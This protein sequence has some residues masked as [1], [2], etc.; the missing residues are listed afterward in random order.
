MPEPGFNEGG[1]SK[2]SIDI[3]M[4]AGGPSK[5][6]GMEPQKVSFSGSMK[7]EDNQNKTIL[8]DPIPGTVYGS[9]RKK[10]EEQIEAGNIPQSVIDQANV[11]NLLDDEEMQRR[12]QEANFYAVQREEQYAR[13]D[14]ILGRLTNAESVADV[15]ATLDV[16][17]DFM[18][19]SK[20]EASDPYSFRYYTKTALDGAR[21]FSKTHQQLADEGIVRGPLRR[22]GTYGNA[23]GVDGY[24]VEGAQVL[25]NGYAIRVEKDIEEKPNG[26][27]KV[28]ERYYYGTEKERVALANAHEQLM[29]ALITGQKIHEQTGAFDMNRA[30][31]EE[32]VKYFYIRQVGLT[33]EQITWVFTAADIKKITPEAPNNQESGLRRSKATRALY[34]LGKCET[35]EKMEDHLNNTFN[36]DKFLDQPTIKR[37][38]EIMKTVGFVDEQAKGMTDQVK[39]ARFLIG[40]GLTYDEKEKSWKVNWL[41]KNQRD[42]SKATTDKEKDKRG[43]GAIKEEKEVRGFL[44]EFG[45]PYTRGNRDAMYLLLNRIGSIIGDTDNIDV[46]IA[47]RLFWTW[48]EK[49][50]LGLEVYSPENIPTGEQFLESFNRLASEDYEKWRKL[51][52]EHLRYF[53]L[54]G[55]PIG[56]DLSKIFYP[57][58]Y[59]LKDLL[60]DRPTGSPLTVDKFK[61]FTQSLMTLARNEVW[62]GR[63]EKDD[64][65][66]PAFKKKEDGKPE[67]DENGRTI[68]IKLVETRSV[69]EQ[70]LGHK[71]TDGLPEEHAKE[72]GEI[73][74]DQI[75]APAEMEDVKIGESHELSPEQRQ[76]LEK[77]IGLNSGAV[78]DNA[79]GYFWLMNF[80]AGDGNPDKR[81]WAFINDE[82]PDQKKLIKASGFTAKNKFLTIVWHD[83]A[84]VYGDWRK[85]S[86]EADLARKKVK[87]LIKEQAKEAWAIGR[88]AWYA[89]V[90][91]LPDYPTWSSQTLDYRDIESGA[92]KSI[93]IVNYIEQLAVRFGFLDPKEIRRFPK[94][95]LKII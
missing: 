51:A 12:S 7:M 2:S 93:T 9:A 11:V 28:K 17:K 25:Q 70:F 43:T 83:S 10:W 23:I 1:Q 20:A 13:R 89:G 19:W 38:L 37:T 26:K 90:R 76:A 84:L 33:N 36:F 62:C 73:G 81:P 29:R 79:M 41:D 78:A 34:L 50:E 66:K 53:S 71:A 61:R 31:L 63:Y 95:R 92:G 94:Q 47:D 60:N 52:D 39:A 45:N 21:A 18:D 82:S 6:V 80:L 40:K 75:S 65:G 42:P 3:L 4:K 57:Q 85:K 69:R 24:L 27:T 55:E 5:L 77:S 48:G 87:V 35:K 72:M 67:L 32:M 88:K 59:R 22:G 91:A 68:P 86:I 54:P 46:K 8:P 64:E 44:T 49:D 15:V 74:W 30:S 14:R 58:F 16:L 56:S